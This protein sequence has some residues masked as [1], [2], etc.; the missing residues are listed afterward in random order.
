MSDVSQWPLTLLNHIEIS[1]FIAYRGQPADWARDCTG[2]LPVFTWWDIC[3]GSAR[4]TTARG[5]VT[6]RAGEWILIPHGVQRHQLIEKGTQL[7]SLNFRALWPNGKPVIELLNP[8]IG[9][10]GARLATLARSFCRIMERARGD[11][12]SSLM[13]REMSL[14]DWLRSRSIL[15][16][17]TDELVQC[18][19]AKG[20][21]LSG[22]SSG[23]SRLDII[24]SELRRDLRAGP[25]P[26][27]G[28][29]T[30]LGVGR[31]QIDRLT[32]QHLGRALKTMRDTFLEDEIRQQLSLGT[33]SAKE[34]AAKY[35]FADASHF[36]RWVRRMTGFPPTALR[37]S[38]V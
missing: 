7:T 32:R 36:S 27:D 10:K 13:N 18:A 17:F 5:T 34:L 21:V 33:L 20:G 22:P 26:Y 25:L 1:P 14:S 29:R 19:L 35:R 31:S 37:Q 11:R 3:S 16:S 9:P 23:D 28:W 30:R 38:A 8:I 15:Y 6:A 4:V 12:A 2:T 24:L